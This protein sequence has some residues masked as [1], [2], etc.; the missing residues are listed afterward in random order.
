MHSFHISIQAINHHVRHSID[1]A[2]SKIIKAVKARVFE[3][4]ENES[5][6]H[7]VG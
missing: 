2:T 1:V 7:K 3:Q 5:D 6:F 4:K